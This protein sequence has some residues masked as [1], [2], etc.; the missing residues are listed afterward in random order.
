MTYDVM[1]IELSKLTLHPREQWMK[2]SWRLLS[3]EVQ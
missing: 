3:H 2:G 1:T